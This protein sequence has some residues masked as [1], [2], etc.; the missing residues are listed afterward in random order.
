MPTIERIEDFRADMIGWRRDLHA[1]PELGFEEERTA[2]FV[3]E[4]LSSFGIKVHRGLAGTGVVGVLAGRHDDGGRIGLRADMDAL[5]LREENLF[6][7][8]SRYP[9]R[10]HACGHDG[11]MTMLLGA[12]RYL[13]ETRDFNGVIHFI[14][15]PAEE[16]KAGGRVMVEDG[17]FERFPCDRVFGMHNWPLLPPGTF[18]VHSGPVMAAA[19]RF[20]IIITGR[21]TH[22]AIPHHGI[23]SVLVAAHI[24]TAVQGVI[25]RT[26]DPL[27]NAV[28][29]IT[30]VQA[31]SAFN[32]VP[33]TAVLGGTVRTFDPELRDRIE[34]DLTRMA[35]AIAAAFGAG[36]V[37]EYRRSYP[38][39][40]NTSPEADLAAA[41]AAA[42]VGIERVIRDPPPS[43]GA[44]D[45]SFM[46]E[47]RPGAYIWLGQGGGDDG[48]IVHSPHYDFNDDV[49]TIGASYWATLAQMAL[50]PN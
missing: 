29:S 19:D 43:M 36:A 22:A 6:N 42:V 1:H 38:P 3:A 32:I 26:V 15:Q 47:W 28:I 33:E 5:A 49:L 7:H 41:A 17:L 12:A 8:V 2:A 44:E 10:M 40:I 34:G 35:Q 48:H 21:G 4:T 11:H 14:F 45:F 13:A 20:E 25:S 24:I 37:L 50:P 39:T 46:L 16:G 23:D 30:T 27:E 31:G 18:G 9:G